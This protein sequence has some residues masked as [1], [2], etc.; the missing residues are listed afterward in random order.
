M[1]RGVEV[2][3]SVFVERGVAA[4]D[5]TAGKAG[6]EVDPVAADLNALFAADATGLDEL[7]V[8]EVFAEGH[9]RPFVQRY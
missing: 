3:G 8:G 5:V 9:G 1:L 6:A 2:L 7:A 4:A